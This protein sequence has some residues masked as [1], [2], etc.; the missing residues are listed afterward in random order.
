MN[1]DYVRLSVGNV[2]V[3]FVR[4]DG[5]FISC[6]SDD[7]VRLFGK[8]ASMLLHDNIYNLLDSNLDQKEFQS[9]AAKVFNDYEK[10]CLLRTKCKAFL[11][12]D[13]LLNCGEISSVE[14]IPG[15]PIRCH[16]PEIIEYSRSHSKKM[17]DKKTYYAL[18]NVDLSFNDVFEDNIEI[19]RI[20]S[21]SSSCILTPVVSVAALPA[22]NASMASPKKDTDATDGGDWGW[23][24]TISPSSSATFSNITSQLQLL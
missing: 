8:S 4:L 17:A 19:D 7:T 23:F 24:K 14:I 10:T 13:R 6:H 1:E 21:D 9:I 3:A 18:E 2:I 16:S 12:A 11:W 20:K 5:R 15:Q 22:D